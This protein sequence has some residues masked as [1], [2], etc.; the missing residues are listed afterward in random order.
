MKITTIVLLVIMFLGNTADE[1][2]IKPEELMSL[3]AKHWKGTLSYLD[4]SSNK[5]VNIPV[6]LNVIQSETELDNWYFIY[7]YP[8]EPHANGTDTITVNDK[9][10][11]LNN[12]TVSEN[13]YTNDTVFTFTTMRSGEDND[14]KAE[15]KHVYILD[16]STF[17]I[18]KEVKYE[19]ENEFFV[20]NEYKFKK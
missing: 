9:G 4:Y 19:G 1:P 2:A 16:G 17:I 5:E 12:E 20:R 18:R 6:N 14:K 8:D 15:L 13:H 10:R 7:E 3:T 11:K